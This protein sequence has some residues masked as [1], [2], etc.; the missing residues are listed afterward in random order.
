MEK[1]KLGYW[2]IRGRGQVPRLLLAYVGADWE[3]TTYKDAGSW[4]GGDKVN[5]DLDFPNLPY[6][7]KGDIRLTESSAIIRFIGG[8]KPE[9][10][11]KTE[12][13]IAHVDMIMSMLDDLYN[14]TFSLFFSP[15]YEQ[16]KVGLYDNKLKPKIK[17]LIKFI[18]NKDFVFGYPTVVDFKIAEAVYYLEKL[19]PEHNEEFGPLRKLRD[20]VESLEKVQAFYKNGGISA[21]FLP[22]YAKLQ[23]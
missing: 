17:D 21:P 15:N 20:S 13:D 12:K 6:L 23:F 5:M 18:N 2:G 16:A 7:I 22:A 19:Y 8:M 9:L 1:V 10:L 11:G 14:P 4:F 3:E